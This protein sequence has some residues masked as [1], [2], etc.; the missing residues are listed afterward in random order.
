MCAKTKTELKIQ[1]DNL[2]KPNGANEITAAI[3]NIIATDFIDS[4]VVESSGTLLKS[5]KFSG[6]T[7]VTTVTSVIITEVP[8]Y[9]V[10]VFVNGERHSLGDT[11]GSA[12]YFLDTTNTTIHTRG[13]IIATDSLN[14]NSTALGFTLDSADN[15]T[16]SYIVKA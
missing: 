10:F 9:D 11:T 15:I 4:F 3:H 6:I 13:N 16:I 1:V 7:P 2:I 8:L 5:V 14:Y 12:F